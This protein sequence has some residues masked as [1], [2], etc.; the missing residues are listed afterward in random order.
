MQLW[1]FTYFFESLSLITE[2]S[3]LNRFYNPLKLGP[4][5]YPFVIN[6]IGTIDAITSGVGALVPGK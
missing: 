3:A 6:D 5:E 4:I 1:L 2:A